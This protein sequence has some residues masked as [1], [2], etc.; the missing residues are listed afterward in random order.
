MFPVWDKFVYLQGE[1]PIW[2]P[3]FVNLSDEWVYVITKFL[4]TELPP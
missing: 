3:F 2:P 4:L 1:H